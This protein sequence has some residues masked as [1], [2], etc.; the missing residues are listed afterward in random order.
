[1]WGAIVLTLAL[2]L[3]IVYTPLLQPVFKTAS[4]TREMMTVILLVTLGCVLCIEMV[5]RFSRR[6]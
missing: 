3:L 6:K 2:Q 4:L 1:M 5:K